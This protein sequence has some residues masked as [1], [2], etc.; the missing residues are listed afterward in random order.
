MAAPIGP[1]FAD[2]LI[3]LLQLDGGNYDT[4]RP[5]FSGGGEREAEL[6][7]HDD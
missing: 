4:F 5:Y 7:G 2:L 1:K 6:I 3:R